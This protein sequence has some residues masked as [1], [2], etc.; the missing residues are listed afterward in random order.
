M[1]DS[2]GSKMSEA[3]AAKVVDVL[4]MN[5]FEEEAAHLENLLV[6]LASSDE[7]VSKRAASEI[8]GLCQVRSYGNLNI[9]TMNGW[10]WNTLLEKV[11]NSVRRKL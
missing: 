9:K 8:E 4:Q 10:K 7:A 6:L 1:A 11:A 3:N 2:K 5:G